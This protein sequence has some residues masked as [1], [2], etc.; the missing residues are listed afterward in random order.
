MSTEQD[1]PITAALKNRFFVWMDSLNEHAKTDPLQRQF[2]GQ[3]FNIYHTGGGCTGWIKTHPN[4]SVTFITNGNL[5]HAAE[6]E[7]TNWETGNYTA[8]QFEEGITD[9]YTEHGQDHAAAIAA[10]RER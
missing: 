6:G 10:T 8:E 7:I 3:G 1:D 2:L 9:D 5:G 4:S